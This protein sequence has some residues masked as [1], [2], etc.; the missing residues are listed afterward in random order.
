MR[1]PVFLLPN[2]SKES[3]KHKTSVYFRARPWDKSNICFK[4]ES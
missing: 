3:I 2:N 1:E 4:F